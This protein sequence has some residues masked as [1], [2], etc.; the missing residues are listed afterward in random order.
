MNFV[1]AVLGTAQEGSN[2]IFLAIWILL[3]IL[4]RPE[5]FTFS[6]WGRSWDS[7]VFARW[8]HYSRWRFKISGGLF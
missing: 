2:L 5:F 6:R 3:W 7:V 4:D 8:Q 1:W